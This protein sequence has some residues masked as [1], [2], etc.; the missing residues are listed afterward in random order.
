MN[1]YN[2]KSKS[3]FKLLY[4]NRQITDSEGY[5]MHEHKVPVLKP[6]KLDDLILTEV[7]LNNLYNEILRRFAILKRYKLN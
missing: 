5:E 1:F 2:I 6:N 4:E 7:N 3:G